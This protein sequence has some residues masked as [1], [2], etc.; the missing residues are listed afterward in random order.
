L[1]QVDAAKVD[2]DEMLPAAGMIDIGAT[3]R[4]ADSAADPV[5]VRF[6]I[7]SDPEIIGGKLQPVDIVM[8]KRQ[9][10]VVVENEEHRKRKPL[11]M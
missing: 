2:E 3:N 8:E 11:W 9:D 10:A 4:S 7:V 1:G 5:V 6:A